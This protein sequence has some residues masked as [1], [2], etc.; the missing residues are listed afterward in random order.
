MEQEHME[1]AQSP[2]LLTTHLFYRTF[3]SAEMY[4][5]HSK[6]L[7]KMLNHEV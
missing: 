2:F 1:V 3:M 4:F 6:M 5:I 7:K